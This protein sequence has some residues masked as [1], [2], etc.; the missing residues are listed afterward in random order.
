MMQNIY[1]AW[2]PEINRYL[3][4]D[5]PES[6]ENKD[7]SLVPSKQE[8]KEKTE[9][10]PPAENKT[11]ILSISTEGARLV[12]VDDSQVTSSQRPLMLIEARSFCK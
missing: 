12:L 10:K 4:K 3:N 2:M 7:S 1:N 11:E 9:K 8:E 6:N 5:N